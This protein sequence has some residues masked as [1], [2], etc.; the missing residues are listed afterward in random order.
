MTVLRPSRKWKSFCSPFSF[1]SF[2]ISNRGYY[3]SL[4]VRISQRSRT[5]CLVL[6]MPVAKRKFSTSSSDRAFQSYRFRG[7]LRQ[8]PPRSSIYERILTWRRTTSLTVDIIGRLICLFSDISYCFIHSQNSIIYAQRS[9]RMSECFYLHNRKKD[10][11]KAMSFNSNGIST[12]LVK[13]TSH[14][15]MNLERPLV[16]SDHLMTF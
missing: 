1:F 13:I 10:L 4:T 5:T 12:F 6:E 8:P 7:G 3:P 14:Y 11:T 2:V 15:M 16:G 9:T